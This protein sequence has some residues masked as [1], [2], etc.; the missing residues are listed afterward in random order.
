[1]TQEGFKHK[2]IASLSAKSVGYSRLMAECEPSKVETLAAYHEI[3]ASLIKQ[4]RGR[5][6]DSPGDNVLAE[7]S[8]VVD[9]EQYHMALQS[10]FQTPNA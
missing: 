6:V 1:M 10:E 2:L 8:S 4:Y 5:L 3:M 7:F 9:T